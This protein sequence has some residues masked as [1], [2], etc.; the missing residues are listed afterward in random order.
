MVSC[1][2]FYSRYIGT[3]LRT[4]A[5]CIVLRDCNVTTSYHHCQAPQKFFEITTLLSLLADV[6]IRAVM[7][8]SCIACHCPS[9]AV[10][11]ADVTVHYE[12]TPARNVIIPYYHVGPF[13][14]TSLS[15]KHVHQ[16]CSSLLFFLLSP[17]STLSSG[18]RI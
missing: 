12:R 6:G 10:L 16:V 3:I 11:G 9:R 15:R 17:F 2:N 1:G 7:T 18:S 13:L 8:L 14:V 4:V 5:T